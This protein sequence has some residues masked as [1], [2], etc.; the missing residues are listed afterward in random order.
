[1]EPAQKSTQ[2]S[3]KS[4]TANSRKFK[5]FT[6]E[7]RSAMK[8][9]IQELKADE[10]DG[11]DALLAKIAKMP[12]PAHHGQPAPCYHQS[13]LANPLAETLR[14]ESLRLQYALYVA[15]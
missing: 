15:Y 14:G 9:R 13:Q 3:A 4:T 12:E 7:E 10:V 6:D 5:G 2:K 8:E 1:M 11:E